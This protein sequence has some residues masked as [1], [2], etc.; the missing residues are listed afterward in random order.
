MKKIEREIT[1]KELV[2]Y[3]ATDGTMFQ[4]EEEC[5]KYEGSAVGVLMGR[6]MKFTVNKGTEYDIFDGIGCGD[7]EVYVVRPR[8]EKDIDTV[9]QL[10]ELR[11]YAKE[12]AEYYKGL[13]L[14]EQVGKIIFVSVGYD[15]DMWLSTMDALIANIMGDKKDE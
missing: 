12:K 7:T 1:T 10:F 11:G 3:E 15:G 8:D 2:G 9:K 5:A 6:I 4:S 13:K 14:D